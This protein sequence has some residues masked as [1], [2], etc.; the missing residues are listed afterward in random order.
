[1]TNEI[2]RETII[3]ALRERNYNAFANDVIKNG[4]LLQGITIRNESNIAPNIYIDKL[5]QVFDNLD[6]IVEHIINTYES[7]KSIDINISNLTDHDWILEHI[8][9]ALQKSSDEP[10]IKRPCELDDIEEFLYIRGTSINDNW[11]VKL[12]AGIMQSAN[13][14]LNEVWE[15]ATNNTFATGETVIESMAEVLFGM[16]ECPDYIE[17]FSFPKM[18][19]ISNSSKTKGSVQILDKTA[20]RNYFPKEIH[21]LICIPSSTE[22]CILIPV[23]DTDA[24]IDI[25]MYNSM[26][27]EVNASEVE[28]TQQLCSHIFILQI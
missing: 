12:N 28:P 1:M 6:E 8:Y 26:V 20:I 7:N 27:R 21:R 24:D 22:E 16:C 2:T 15:A 19:V 25:E 5:I 3:A 14:S 10:L 18:Y 11:S 17:D 13:L 4:V 9:I 23:E